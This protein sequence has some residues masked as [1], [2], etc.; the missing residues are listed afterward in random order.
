MGIDSSIYIALE[1]WESV[2]EPEQMLALT[3]NLILSGIV[4]FDRFVKTYSGPEDVQYGLFAAGLNEEARSKLLDEIIRVRNE[5]SHKWFN[6][7]DLSLTDSFHFELS[8][9]LQTTQLMSD[10]RLYARFEREDYP[11]VVF[12]LVELS[13]REIRDGILK[14][15]QEGLIQLRIYKNETIHNG[16]TSVVKNK[17]EDFVVD[18]ADA[19]NYSVYDEDDKD[20]IQAAY[21]R[22]DEII[23]LTETGCGWVFDKSYSFRRVELDTTKLDLQILSERNE[24]NEEL[25]KAVVY[26][27]DFVFSIDLRKDLISPEKFRIFRDSEPCRKLIA[28]VE[29]AFGQKAYVT[30]D[31]VV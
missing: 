30:S 24:F 2:P 25:Y 26:E 22:G 1:D 16:K 29:H 15:I 3:K 31:F 17:H 28:C 4:D 7:S 11:A 6:I 19:H 14:L 8:E 21:D 23:Y 20:G 9:L 18:P 5:D 12:E 13:F 27:G 10:I